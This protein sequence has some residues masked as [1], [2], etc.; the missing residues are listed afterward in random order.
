MIGRLWFC[1]SPSDNIVY[2]P[3]SLC[4]CGYRPCLV[5][6]LSLG[7]TRWT[8][9][10]IYAPIK[11]VV[12]QLRPH[13]IVCADNKTAVKF[14]AL[15]F[16]PFPLP[17]AS[18]PQDGVLTCTILH[19]SN[20]HCGRMCLI[21]ILSLRPGAA[22]EPTTE[23]TRPASS[24]SLWQSH[25]YGSR[26]SPSLIPSPNFFPFYL[27]IS[28]LIWTRWALLSRASNIIDLLAVHPDH[29]EYTRRL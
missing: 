20:C 25:G 23:T 16:I 12:C 2:R 28:C 22:M 19:S 5:L 14:L 6:C 24:R 21:P 18:A 10:L 1:G 17:L 8:S 11:C 7:A 29:P 26:V 4:L 27:A 13:V 3:S 15:V 9:S